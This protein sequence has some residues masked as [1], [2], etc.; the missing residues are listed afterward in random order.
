MKA[1]PTELQDRLDDVVTSWATC[2]KIIRKD[3]KVFAA[4]DF[5]DDLT[6]GGV[7]YK[8]R[9]GY[10]RTAMASS[11]TMA[12]DNIDV[13]GAYGVVDHEDLTDDDLRSGAY[14]GAE[15][16][17]LL[18]DHR[19][20]HAGGVILKRGWIGEVT[21]RE[22]RYTS[23]IRGL[24]DALRTQ[25]VEST[26]PGCRADFGDSR[27]RFNVAS[28]SVSGSVSAVIDSIT[29]RVD[30]AAAPDGHWNGGHV[31]YTTAGGS[32]VSME[33]R[34]SNPDG[35]LELLLAPAVPFAVGNAV[36]VAPGCTKDMAGCKRWSNVVN[37]V[38]EPHVPGDRKALSY[39]DAK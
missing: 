22:H 17:V 30:A 11:S 20:P 29:M 23:E 14:D 33:I 36:T 5:H 32:V 13:E 24:A 27:C 18:V 34:R 6:I 12:P 15:V 31:R 28:V 16:Q 10:T 1:F 35:T 4:T 38:G 3:G 25:V 19:Q 26:T 37:F 39:P 21:L 7:T 2:W 9:A 8:A